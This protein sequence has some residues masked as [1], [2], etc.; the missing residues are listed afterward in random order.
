LDLC[1]YIY[2]REVST[3]VH[4]TVAIA[5]YSVTDTTT[6]SLTAIIIKALKVRGDLS[7]EEIAAKFVSFGA[8]GMNVFQ[9]V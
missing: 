7:H 8:D 3:T 1:P 4:A 9:G 5:S 6:Q 2:S